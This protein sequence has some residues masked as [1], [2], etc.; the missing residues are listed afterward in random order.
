MCASSWPLCDLQP[1]PSGVFATETLS[2]RHSLGL[3]TGTEY[4]SAVDSCLDEYNLTNIKL[5]GELLW[6]LLLK[7]PV[8]RNAPWPRANRR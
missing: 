1:L 3:M 6:I 8:L 4:V 2:V 7:W 5:F